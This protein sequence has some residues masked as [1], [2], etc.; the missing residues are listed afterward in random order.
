MNRKSIKEK[1]KSREITIGSWITLGHS[2]IAE[3]MVRAGFDWLTIDMEH[4]AITLS[5]SQQLIQVIELAGCVPLV[6]V[7]E[8]NPNLIKQ[9]MDAGAHGVIVPMVNSREEA[10]AAV[11]A[12]KYPPAGKRGV[13]LGRAQGYG[14][15]FEEYRE[16]V[17]KES[18]VIVQVEH[19]RAVEHLEEIFS[20]DGVDGFLVGPYDLSGS[21]GVPGEFEHPEM[22]QALKR[23]QEVALRKKLSA[24]IHVITPDPQ[25]IL[26]KTREGFTFIAFSLDTLFL[27][28]ACR[29]ALGS[30]RELVGK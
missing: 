14:V 12:V 27:N 23:I 17:A 19:I 9:V 3:I 7:G 24:G 28:E 11:A 21:L 10:E 16:W 1:L 22:K 29:S 20:V 8:N 4:S 13:G 25:S 5:Q 6:R 2:S 30:A 26:D 18:V 15:D